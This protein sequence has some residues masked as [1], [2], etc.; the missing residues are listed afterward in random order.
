MGGRNASRGVIGA[1]ILAFLLFVVLVNYAPDAVAL[2][3]NNYGWNGLHDVA[4]RYDLGFTTSLSSI[5]PRS[6]LVVMEPSVAY[7]AEDANNVRGFLAGGGT[8]LVADK[9]GVANSLLEGLGVPIYIQSGYAIDDPVYNWKAKTVPTALVPPSSAARFPQA[10]NVTGLALNQ[11]SPLGVSPGAFVIG[12]TSQLSYDVVE[13][14]SARV[15]SGP[16]AVAAVAKVG[17][18]TVFVVGDPQLLFNSEWTVADNEALIGNLFSGVNVLIDASHWSAGPL[19][20][21]TAQLKAEFGEVY[22]AVSAPPTSYVVA[23][24]MVVVAIG[25]APTKEDKTPA[26]LASFSREVPGRVEKVREGNAGEA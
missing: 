1:A 20:S 23:L 11:P 6:V 26:E 15:A 16:F 24:A 10:A 3:P 7:S 22:E 19:S 4:S 5:S 8:L 17:P 2:S 14:T 12:S 18:G 13:G 9:S 21:S 25:L